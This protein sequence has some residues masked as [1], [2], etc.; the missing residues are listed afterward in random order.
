MRLSGKDLS[1]AG[2]SALWTHPRE[3]TKAA[4]SLDQRS[5]P[6]TGSVLQCIQGTLPGGSLGDEFW[7]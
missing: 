7:E 3:V 2:H 1:L 4:G 5:R 6:R